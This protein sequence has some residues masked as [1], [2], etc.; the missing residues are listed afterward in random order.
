M[1]KVRENV[2][3]LDKVANL[4]TG[5]LKFNLF[6]GVMSKNQFV[7]NKTYINAKNYCEE[8]ICD[9]CGYVDFAKR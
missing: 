5:L 7:C 8:V 9:C 4:Y 1:N 6:F 2:H 3:K